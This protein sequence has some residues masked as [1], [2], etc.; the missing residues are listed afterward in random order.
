MSKGTIAANTF[1]TGI[2]VAASTSSANTDLFHASY[3]STNECLDLSPMKVS[4]VKSHSAIS[5]ANGSLQATDSGLAQVCTGLGTPTK[6]APKVASVTN[7]T[8]TLSNTATTGGV[9]L[10]E[11]VSGDTTAVTISGETA[12]GG[13]HSH[14][15]SFAK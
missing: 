11:S 3:D 14:S 13:S 6:S 8:I 15:V 1:A 7:P 12:T 10:L 4:A 2:S 5:Y 9:E